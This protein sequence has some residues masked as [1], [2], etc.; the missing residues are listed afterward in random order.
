MKTKKNSTKTLSQFKDEHYGTRGTAKR[1]KLEAG[2][3]TFKMGALIHDARL[4][5][6]LTQ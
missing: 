6:G 1:D 3:E 4:E 5:K 2:Y